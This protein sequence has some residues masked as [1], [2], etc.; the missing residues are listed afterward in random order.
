MPSHKNFAGILQHNE[1]CCTGEPRFNIR[2]SAC[3]PGCFPVLPDLD[4]VLGKGMPKGLTRKRANADSLAATEH[5][6]SGQ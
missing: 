5:S 3:T 2:Y 4:Y 6:T 1:G